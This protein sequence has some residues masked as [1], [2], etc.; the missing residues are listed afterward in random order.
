MNKSAFQI[1]SA[2]M[3]GA[4]LLMTSNIING[5]FGTIATWEPFSGI[6]PN[7]LIMVLTLPFMIN[8]VFSVLAGPIA[9]II[10]KKVTMLAG[11]VVILVAGIVALVFGKSNF[12]LLLTASA[13][14]GVGQGL[15]STLTMALPADYFEGQ[16]RAAL[17]GLQSSF[18]N[19]GGMIIAFIGALLSGIDWIYAYAVAFVTIPIFIL[20]SA[21]LPNKERVRED[22]P[23]AADS[24][25]TKAKGSF[26]SFVIIVLIID[27]IYAAFMFTF[28]ANFSLYMTTY[29]LGTVTTAGL[30]QTV[31][32]A[33]GGVAGILYGKMFKG[34]KSQLATFSFVITAIGMIQLVVF[35]GLANVF[36]AGILSG[37]GLTCAIPTFFYNVS[38]N[39]A[40]SM[41]TIALGIL[42]GVGAFA[43]F[44]SPNIV[45]A[46]TS[47]FMAEPTIEAKLIVSS[48][49]LLALAVVSFFVFS[50]SDKKAAA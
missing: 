34:F 15:L 27:I 44:L 11:I 46:V 24:N 9:K 45:G 42:N 20:V 48:V 26:S 31:T 29:G 36:I 38:N 43:I 30:V 5:L 39:V 10:S 19:F 22:S 1:K 25:T 41:A 3:A 6:A 18:V 23:V 7:I 21:N 2:I 49:V 28:S 47:I 35:G 32:S 16:E 37:F 33:L 13:L 40:P 14:F 17:M 12:N 4:M 50:K 8:M